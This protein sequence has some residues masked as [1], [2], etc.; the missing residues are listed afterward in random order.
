MKSE[1]LRPLEDFCKTCSGTFSTGFDDFQVFAEARESQESEGPKA[2]AGEPH[3][4]GDQDSGGAKRGPQLPR[5][6]GANEPGQTCT[7]GIH[8]SAS[9]QA[10]GRPAI[11]RRPDVRRG[12]PVQHLP[13]TSGGR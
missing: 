12:G 3:Q 8:R 7:S 9:T 13:G 2:Q 10:R 6:D 1:T 4:A 5:D 11:R